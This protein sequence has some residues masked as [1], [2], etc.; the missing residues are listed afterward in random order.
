MQ[1]SEA[2]ANAVGRLAAQLSPWSADAST[3][4]AYAYNTEAARSSEWLRSAGTDGGAGDR[5]LQWQTR[6]WVPLLACPA[7]PSTVGQPAVAPGDGPNQQQQHRSPE[8]QQQQQHRCLT[9]S[10]WR[11]RPG[12]LATAR[13]STHGL[14]GKCRRQQPRDRSRKAHGGIHKRTVAITQRTLL[15]RTHP[16]NYKPPGNRSKEG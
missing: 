13:E 9:G 3:V 5:E 6:R 8:P 1:C 10:R 11:V 15:L 12:R 16:Y 14:N 4:T 7:V 2:E